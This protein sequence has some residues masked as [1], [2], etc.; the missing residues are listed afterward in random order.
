MYSLG[1]G[2]GKFLHGPPHLQHGVFLVDNGRTPFL[3]VAGL[4]QGGLRFD[5]GCMTPLDARARALTAHFAEAEQTATSH[6]WTGDGRILVIDNRRTLH[7]REA[8]SS[9]DEERTLTRLAVLA[10]ED[11]T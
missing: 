10:G 1:P 7:A 5:P 2:P 6:K 8:M 3:S 9:G 11:R 4:P